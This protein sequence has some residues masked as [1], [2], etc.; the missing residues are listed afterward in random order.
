[1]THRFCHSIKIHKFTYIVKKL[2]YQVLLQTIELYPVLSISIGLN[3]NLSGSIQF[4]LVLSSSFHLYSIIYGDIQFFIII[5]YYTL[6][7]GVLSTRILLYLVISISFY[8]FHYIWLYP[9]FFHFYSII[10]GYIQFF[11]LIY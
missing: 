2:T 8:S 7:Y 11:P 1:M 10:A 6:L 9:V 4:F 3:A 5:F